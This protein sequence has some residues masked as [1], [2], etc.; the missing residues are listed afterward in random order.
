[1]S[2]RLAMIVA[3]D[4]AGVSV[5]QIC[6]EV[7]I[8]RKTF[9]ELR[10]RY[11]KEGLSGL[12][13]R[14]R[15]PLSSPGQIPAV[16]ER[17]ICQLRTELL[18]DNGAQAIFYRLQREGADPLPSV[19]TVHRVLVRHGL[20]TPQPRK[21]PRSSWRRFEYDQ[22][23]ACWQIDAT[24]WEL[25][26]GRTVWIMEI[27]DDNSRVLCASDAVAGETFDAA[28][29]TF[30]HAATEY[31]LPARVLSDNGAAFTG[32]NG[33]VGQF[34]TNLAALGVQKINSSPRHPQTCGKVER[35]H[36]TLKRWLSQQPPARSI[37]ELQR[38]LDRYRHYYNQQRPHRALHG[39]TPAERFNSTSKALPADPLA[40][41]GLAPRLSI[42]DRQV[43]AT[44]CLNAACTSLGL[45]AAWAGR[46]LTIITYGQRVAILDGTTLIAAVTVDATKKY[47]RVVSPMS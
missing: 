19:R 16:L 21:R 44:G 30:Q 29:K 13:P 32:R 31:G 8:S 7:G 25:L 33:G 18:V 4:T 11:E 22:P 34:P 39:A 41:P 38:Q 35:H 24:Q 23:N 12:E 40:L 2:A 43:S 20:V 27:L 6:R 17:R 28:W 45:G 10:K 5:T 47:Q 1:M 46:T 14:S 37:A 15:R 42:F 26:H 36:Q 3:A 9:Y